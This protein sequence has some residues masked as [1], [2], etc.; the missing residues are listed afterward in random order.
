VLTPPVSLCSSEPIPMSVSQ[1]AIARDGSVARGIGFAVFCYAS[2]STGDAMI[3]LASARFSVFQI[4]FTVALFALVP[5][6]V[7]TRGQGG[8]RALLPRRWPLVALRGVLTAVCALLAWRA[9]SLLPLAEGYAILFATPILVTGLSSVLLGEEVG[10]RRWTAAAVGFLGVLIMIRPDFATL[11]LGHLLA[12]GAALTGA[13][14]LITL[15]RIG[16]T[17]KSASILFAVFVSI[18]TAAAPMLPASFV[19]PTWQEVG[20]LALAGLLM[21]CGQAGIVLAT[22]DAPAVVVAPFQYTQM[23]WGVLFGVL[24][25]GDRPVPVLFAGMA[26]VVGSGCYTLWR[27]VVRQRPVTLGGGR[28]EVPAREAR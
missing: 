9:F 23:V 4:A 17:E 22:R 15:K 8:W 7:L 25:F 27:E 19:V 2:F 10:W 21:G 14:G 24:L 1:V 6:L 18:M 11:G 20:V 12:A 5:V 16:S 13:C 3:K 26:L 28:G